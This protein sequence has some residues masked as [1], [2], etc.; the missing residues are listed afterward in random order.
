MRTTTSAGALAAGLVLSLAATLDLGSTAGAAADDQK[1]AASTTTARQALTAAQ[2][3]L[4]GRSGR[5]TRDATLVLR[6]LA[7]QRHALA[8]ADR[9]A[10]DSILSRPTDPGDQ[11][12]YSVP[13]ERLCGVNV[14]VH[15]VESS[16]D[17]VDLT[18]T[19]PANGI[20]DYVDTVLTTMDD[21]HQTYVDAGYHQ[22]LPDDGQG[23]STLPD[24]YLSNIGPDGLY[25]Y[26]TTDQQNWVDGYAV[27]AYCVLDN[28][29]DAAEFPTNTPIENMQVT[30]AHEYYHA[31]QFAYDILED[32]WF[33]EATATWAED[34]LYDDVDDNVFYLPYGPLGMPEVPLDEFVGLH[35]YGDWIFFRYLTELLDVDQGGM[36]ALLLDFWERADSTNGASNDYYSLQAIKSVLAGEGVSL[37][38]VFARFAAD[39]NHPESTY[40]EGAANAYPYPPYDF[41]LAQLTPGSPGT[42]WR[43]V[44]LDHLTSATGAYTP[45]SAMTQDDWMLKVKV[46]MAN[47]SRGSEV[48]IIVY[49]PSGPQTFAVSL[50]KLG[51]GSRSVPFDYDEIAA[52][53]VVLIN[54]SDRFNCWASNSSPFSCQGAP[55]DDNLTQKVSA[56]AFR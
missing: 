36:P 11:D 1:A 21:V 25:G 17:S 49:G 47:R 38:K 53:E 24:I 32:G 40:E 46:D 50:N 31:V 4:A 33:M 8:G 28:D 29:Y 35:Q 41:P 34:E 30:A 56:T 18:D 44:K 16:G 43:S 12:Q 37:R 22:T 55:K 42:G 20:P 26:C 14:C 23:G 19:S 9:K 13:S 48:Q 3:V 54:A 52:V 39:N 45:S 2:D 6:D 27:Y 15:W 7:A 5:P 51:V 10:A